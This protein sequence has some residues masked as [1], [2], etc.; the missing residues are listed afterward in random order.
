MSVHPLITNEVI[1]GF[2]LSQEVNGYLQKA[3]ASVSSKRDSLR[4]LTQA[5][6]TSPDQLETLVAMY[7]FLFYKGEIE[8]AEE[9]VFQALVKASLQGKFSNNW[10]E[11]NLDSADWSAS[12]G[13]ARIYLYSLKALAFIRLR[14]NMSRDAEKILSVLARLDPEDQVGADVIRDLLD[15]VNG[16]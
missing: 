14:Q 8:K 16:N 1:F 7:K 13:P 15:G 11:L 2:N 12:N 9:V 4:A 3:A 10:K 6:K 5:L